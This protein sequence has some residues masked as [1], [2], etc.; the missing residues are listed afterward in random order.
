MQSRRL[1]TLGLASLAAA[2]ALPRV[3]A[4]Q[5]Q[6]DDAPP[7]D[8]APGGNELVPYDDRDPA[9]LTDFT[10][11]LEPHG[12]WR[13]DPTYGR[14]WVPHRKVVGADFAP[15]VTSGHWAVA[16]DGGWIWVS[17]YTWGWVPFHYGRWVWISGTGWAWIPG[18]QYAHAW[19]TW[20][21]ADPGYAYVGW[22]P[23]PPDYVW[24]DGVA[25]G[26]WFSLYTPWVFCPSAYAY[27][28]HMHSY[29]VHDHHHVHDIAAHSHRY[30]PPRGSPAW[31]GP[32]PRRAYVP[33]NAV[34]KAH[35]P[36]HPKAVAAARQKAS[37]R[38]AKIVT[39]GRRPGPDARA[40]P[41]PRGGQRS[42]GPDSRSSWPSARPTDRRA[43]SHAWSPSNPSPPSRPSAPS[44]A[45]PS[46]RPSSPSRAAPPSRSPE[47]Y[48]SPE[49]HRASPPSRSSPPSGYRSPSPAPVPSYR[50]PAP[51]PARGR[52]GRRR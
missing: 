2:L 23:M 38:N 33:A 44:R 21:V 34:P 45:A 31:A 22:A 18:R 27:H 48:R 36:A 9:A 1:F 47:P 24:F 32:S 28:H 49:P 41:G 11:E 25:V 13:D 30:V 46:S 51:A 14:V 10:A 3:A 50:P 6:W 17:D 5:A 42:P 19:V 4:A 35:T 40:L 20:R 37:D 12:A 8:A 43:P 26:V 16:D 7:D 15:Y 52:P 29:I 39:P